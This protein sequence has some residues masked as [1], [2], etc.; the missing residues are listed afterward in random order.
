MGSANLG[1]LRG[2]GACGSWLTAVVHEWRQSEKVTRQQDVTRQKQTT[3]KPMD[4]GHIAWDTPF[5]SPSPSFSFLLSLSL[6]PLPSPKPFLSPCRILRCVFVPFLCCPASVLW[7]PCFFAL[8]PVL[9]SACRGWVSVCFLPH[10]PPSRRLF[11]L[12]VVCSLCL[13]SA[14]VAF[15]SFPRSL[16]WLAVL[17]P[18]HLVRWS[19]VTLFTVSTF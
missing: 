11:C 13:L 3:C 12:L 7:L 2:L 5:L 14:F 8:L 9:S 19:L 15:L 4:A 17:V 10:L 6:P 16:L 1:I 18:S